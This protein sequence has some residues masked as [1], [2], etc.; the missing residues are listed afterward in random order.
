MGEDS[1][2]RSIFLC[3]ISG[4]SRKNKSFELKARMGV[5][6]PELCPWPT[7]EKDAGG[8]TGR[9]TKAIDRRRRS[10]VKQ[11]DFRRSGFYNTA[12]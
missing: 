11:K 4:D 9:I 8:E 12:D 3:L 6:L 7:R 2:F 10:G 5:D 1:E